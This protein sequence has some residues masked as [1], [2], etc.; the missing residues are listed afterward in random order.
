MDYGVQA[1]TLAILSAWRHELANE[2]QVIAGYL[3]L[4]RP[5]AALERAL[6]AGTRFHR[7]DRLFS[8]KTSGLAMAFLAERS[9]ARAHGV[10]IEF[11]I[12]SDL[13]G[14]TPESEPVLAAALANLLRAAALRVSGSDS[15]VFSL[16]VAEDSAGYHFRLSNAEADMGIV[17]PR[18]TP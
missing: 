7:L 4:G 10:A 8:L 6:D 5:G 9:H 18:V 15:P 12:G 1:E 2:L 17:W 3:Q 16:V 13:A 14:V 11:E